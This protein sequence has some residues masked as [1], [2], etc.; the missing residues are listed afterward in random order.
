MGFALGLDFAWVGP[1]YG[2]DGLDPA[3]RIDGIV[4]K[5]PLPRALAP[6]PFEA[7]AFQVASDIFIGF[8]V[9]KD[10]QAVLFGM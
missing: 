8:F 4:G 6:R 7:P 9:K 1:V 2:G 5:L 3:C 10:L